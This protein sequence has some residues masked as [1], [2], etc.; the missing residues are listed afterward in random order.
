MDDF[1]DADKAKVQTTRF[2]KRNPFTHRT[3]FE[4]QGAGATIKFSKNV[5]LQVGYTTDN[6]NVA[7]SGNGIGG[8]YDLGTQL[9]LKAGG[10]KIGATYVRSEGNTGSGLDFSHK[11]GSGNAKFF[12][13]SDVE[14]DSFGIQAST[15]LGKK[16]KVGAWYGFTNVD[17]D[18]TGNDAT[19]QN[20]A[21]FASIKDFAKKG[22][23]LGITF[24]MP[25]KVTDA[26]T[27]TGTGA[28]EDSDTSY[29]LDVTYRHKV[30]DRLSLQPGFF[31]VFN[32]NHDNSNST[33]YGAVLNTTFKF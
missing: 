13:G 27:V 3:N 17:E 2:A 5:N 6:G 25:P 14:S 19:L 22:N 26:N 16:T 33:I 30:T 20:W 24:G 23:V 9:N 21:V 29:L 1:L 31:A 28:T 7:G 18:V 15:K 11:T 8:N 10:F 32:P 4:E 12:T